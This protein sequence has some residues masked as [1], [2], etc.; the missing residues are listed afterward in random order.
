MGAV[1]EREVVYRW[2]YL[3]TLKK[4]ADAADVNIKNRPKVF[5]LHTGQA[6]ASP[7]SLLNSPSTGHNHCRWYGILGFN[8]PLDT[9]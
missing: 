3:V 2:T 5:N 1:G 6:A 9:L 4:V 8:V 7:D